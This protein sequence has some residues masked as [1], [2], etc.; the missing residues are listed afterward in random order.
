MDSFEVKAETESEVLSSTAY[1][2]METDFT[3]KPSAPWVNNTELSCNWSEDRLEGMVGSVKQRSTDNQVAYGRFQNRGP[4][5][6][7]R[8][9][10]HNLRRKNVAIKDEVFVYILYNTSYVQ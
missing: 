8:E 1:P 9:G 3:K 5:I 7:I 2:S 6:G 10:N 4:P